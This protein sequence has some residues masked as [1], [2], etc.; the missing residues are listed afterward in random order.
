MATIVVDDEVTFTSGLQAIATPYAELRNLPQMLASLSRRFC[1]TGEGTVL[2]SA[3]IMRR[4]GAPDAP[5]KTEE[6]ARAHPWLTPAREAG[7]TVSMLSPWMTFWDKTDRRA[8]VHVGLLPWMDSEIFELIDPDPAV[9]AYRMDWISS[10]MRTAYRTRPGIVGTAAVKRF[11]P[12]ATPR[13]RPDWK[14]CE[15]VSGVLDEDGDE[16]TTAWELRYIWESPHYDDLVAG[17]RWLHGWDIRKQFLAAASMA[18]LSRDILVHTGAKQFDGTP[19]YWKVRVPAWNLP[20]LPHPMGQYEVDSVQWVTTPTMELCYRIAEK[21]G[22][23]APPVVLDSWTAPKGVRLLRP[24]AETI[25]DMLVAAQ[26][27]PDPQDAVILYEASKSLYTHAIDHWGNPRSTVWRYDWKHTIHGLA[28]CGVFWKML[29]EYHASGRK[30][31]KIFHD[32]VYYASNEP[33]PEQDRPIT[34]PISDFIGKFKYG[35]SEELIAA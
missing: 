30:P 13:W 28:R 24:W 31:V 18:E 11:V 25:R 8:A 2:L 3:D 21:Y 5:A 16:R 22:Y 4:L 29:E 1:S 20:F 34:F 27:E 9:M 15:P 7:W 17:Y 14:Y 10:R 12:G 6:G 33:D 23:I 35:H 32:M 19:G 26:R